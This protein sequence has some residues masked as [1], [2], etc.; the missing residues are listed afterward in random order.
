MVIVPKMV[1]A[2]FGRGPF[3]RRERDAAGCR[4]NC[5]APDMTNHFGDFPSLNVIPLGYLCFIMFGVG[6]HTAFM[7]S[8]L[9]SLNKI[10]LNL[11]VE[12]IMYILTGNVYSHQK[13]FVIFLRSQGSPRI[14]N[15]LT[16]FFCYLL[17]V[18]VIVF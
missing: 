16:F 3:L 8:V 15:F 4:C 6:E 9:C 12:E 7:V 2:I 5:V 13:S 10:G 17:S 18:P 14:P 11:N 1:G